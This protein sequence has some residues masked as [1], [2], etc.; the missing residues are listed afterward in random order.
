MHNYLKFTA[1]QIRYMLCMLR[2][3]QGG[4]GVKN[5]EIATAFAYSKSSVHNMLRSLAEMGVIDQEAFGLAH[6][7]ET[8]RR[9]AK[10]YEL[11]FLL[12]QSKLNEL[13]GE[14]AAT[15]IAICGVLADMPLPKI[16]ELCNKRIT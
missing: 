7:T 3:S 11:C 14:D 4:C 9:L 16:D 13:C 10:K 12:L 1:S 5:V 8:G 6:F 2:L 15:E